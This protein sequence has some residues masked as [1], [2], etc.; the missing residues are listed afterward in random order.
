M[1]AIA[2]RFDERIIV[3]S[4]GRTATT[5]ATATPRFARFLTAASTAAIAVL[6]IVVIL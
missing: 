1:I 2:T 3:A 5:P 6:L 4:R